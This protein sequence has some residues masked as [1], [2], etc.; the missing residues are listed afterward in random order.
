MAA[1]EAEVSFTGSLWKGVWSALA[2]AGEGGWVEEALKTAPSIGITLSAALSTGLSS[3]ATI[4]ITWLSGAA[5]GAETATAG[6]ASLAA[7]GD[8]LAGT[9][10]SSAAETSTVRGGR[11]AAVGVIRRGHTCGVGGCVG[12][13]VGGCV[14][15]GDH[16]CAGSGGGEAN[17]ND[18]GALDK[19]ANEVVED[20]EAKADGAGGAVAAAGAAAEAAAEAARPPPSWMWGSGSEALI[21]SL[22]AC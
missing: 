11:G 16:H 5:A 7:L 21:A 18:D 8:F 19:V 6:T 9:G 3:A 1:F 22:M 12:S 2:R 10:A 20:E 4:P 14:G 13:C 17:A 15:V